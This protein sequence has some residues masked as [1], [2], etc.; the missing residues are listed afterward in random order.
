VLINCREGR[1]EELELI[2][3]VEV[4]SGSLIEEVDE[5]ISAEGGRFDKT[6]SD[7]LLNNF[8]ILLV[9]SR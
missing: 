1:E 4:G 9:F 2:W 7:V 8:V 5:L 6:K 3:L